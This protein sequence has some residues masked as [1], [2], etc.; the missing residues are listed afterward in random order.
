VVEPKRRQVPEVIGDRELSVNEIV[1][2]LGW[3]QPTVS[4]HIRVLKQ[5][6]LLRER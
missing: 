4:K 5:I 3:N 2:L 1:E 6:G